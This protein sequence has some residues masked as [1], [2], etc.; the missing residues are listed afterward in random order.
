MTIPWLG[1]GAWAA[2][3]K[4]G[5][6]LKMVVFPEPSSLLAIGTTGGGERIV[7]AKVTEGLFTYDFDLNPLTLPPKNVS[8][9]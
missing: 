7:S 4:R 2:T 6:T 3:P 9:G 5:G 8:Q 1:S